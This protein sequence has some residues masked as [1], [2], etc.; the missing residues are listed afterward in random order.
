MC[1]G[2]P[3]EEEGGGGKGVAKTVAQNNT[4]GSGPTTMAEGAAEDGAAPQETN[5]GTGN[6]AITSNNNG[7]ASEEQPG[8][9]MEEGDNQEGVSSGRRRGKC[10]W[11]NVAKG[12]GFITPDDGGQDVFVHQS[13]IQM[14]GFRSLGD[15]EEVEFACKT[16][17][18]GL[19]ATVVTG[20]GGA[21]CHGSHRRPMTKKRFRKIRCYNCGEFANHVAAKCTMGPQPKRCHHCKSESH[22]IAECTLRKD[23]AKGGEDEDGDGAPMEGNGVASEGNGEVAAENHQVPKNSEESKS[24]KDSDSEMPHSTSEPVLDPSPTSEN[25]P[26]AEGDS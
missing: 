2:G 18:K 8:V 7:S 19:E 5:N 11:F 1:V 20:P 22:L 15:E 6:N 24:V 26:I 13:V 9:T 12:W 21:D 17:E 23:R 10:K 4:N 16:S 3:A 25:V 14:S